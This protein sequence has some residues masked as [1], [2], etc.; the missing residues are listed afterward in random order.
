MIVTP[1]IHLTW[2]DKPFSWGIE[3]K[4]VFQSLKAS[5]M[6]ASFFIH[7]NLSKPFILEKDT[8]DFALGIVLSQLGKDN[9]FHL[10]GFHSHK[11]SFVEISYK[12]HGK[13]TFGHHG[14]L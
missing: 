9:F 5:L 8:F 3:A 7:V 14:C 10:I 12:V 6:I 11:F 1:L 2:E 13:K 4:N